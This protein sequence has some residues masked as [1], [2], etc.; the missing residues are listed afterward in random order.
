MRLVC[1]SWSHRDRVCAAR[2]A[3]HQADVVETM[4]RGMLDVIRNNDLELAA[5]LRANCEAHFADAVFDRDR[6]SSMREQLLTV[7]ERARAIAFG[8]NFQ[9]L[10]NKERRL[11]AIGYRGDDQKLDEGEGVTG[12]GWGTVRLR[13]LSYAG[14]CF[15]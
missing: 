15:A 6:M 9:F 1:L 12:G 11:L 13:S 4:L 10:F 14:H 5:R 8:M 3:L 7:G 2:E